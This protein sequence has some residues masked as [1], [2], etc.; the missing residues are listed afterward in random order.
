MFASCNEE[1]DISDRGVTLTTELEYYAEGT[2]RILAFWENKTKFEITYGESWQL[3][4]YDE[5]NNKWTTVKPIGG[6]FNSIGIILL[7]E[8]RRKHTYHVTFFDENITEGRYRIKTDFSNDSI[9]GNVEERQYDVTAE[10]AVTSDKSLLKKSE[11]DYD[12]LE[13]SREMRI[14]YECYDFSKI[15]SKGMDFPVH[16]YKNKKTY[17][18][19]IVINGDEYYKIAEGNGKWGI[20]M[21]SLYAADDG[22][23]YLIYSYSREDN[24]KKSYI[25]IFDLT[26]RKEIYRSEAYETYDI[27]INYRREPV[28]NEYGEKDIFEAGFM[29]H[30]ENEYGGSGQSS[31]PG[32]I[33]YYK[34]ENGTFNFYKS[35]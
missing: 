35:E 19:T 13:N 28:T 3:E 5:E 10:F 1:T 32:K 26:A 20:V 11:L 33:G 4:K 12:D 16:V 27:S 7:P 9:E 29:E 2:A 34:Y 30:E 6:F 8:W 14:A 24:G 21:C 18:T 22:G 17:D 23:K 25:G 15:F 31:A